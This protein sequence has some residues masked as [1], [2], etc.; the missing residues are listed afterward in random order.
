VPPATREAEILDRIAALHARVLSTIEATTS[1]DRREALRAFAENLSKAFYRFE[2][3]FFHQNVSRIV[4]EVISVFRG[5]LEL[6][7][8]LLEIA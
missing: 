5:S 4:D 1:T 3:D 7:P 6:W 8:T 2:P